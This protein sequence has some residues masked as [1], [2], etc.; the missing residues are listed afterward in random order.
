MKWAKLKTWARKKMNGEMDRRERETK[1][2][3]GGKKVVG[4]WRQRSSR[5]TKQKI[6]THGN[7]RNSICLVFPSLTK[8]I[9]CLIV[10][11]A[12]SPK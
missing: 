12:R 9:Y 5:K 11:K 6:L 7:I 4:E 10:L 1:I 2:R 8:Q 3:I